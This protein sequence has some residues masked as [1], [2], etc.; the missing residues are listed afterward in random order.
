MEGKITD[1]QQL[2]LSIYPS[3]CL[4]VFTLEQPS[5]ADTLSQAKKFYLALQLHLALEP[6]S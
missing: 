1:C 6:G 5:D 3:V 4:S 2:C